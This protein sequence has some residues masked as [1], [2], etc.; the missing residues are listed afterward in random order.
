MNRADTP[1][2]WLATVYADRHRAYGGYA[3]RRAEARHTLRGLA[4]GLVF[5]ALVFLVPM[6]VYRWQQRMAARVPAEQVRVVTYHQLAPPPPI[7]R[8]EPPAPPPEAPVPKAKPRYAPPVVKPD[9]EVPDEELPP[10]VEE[11]ALL[12]PGPQARPGDSVIWA[13]EPVAVAEPEPEPEPEP[14]APV[15]PFVMAEVM[16]EFPGG[17]E[18]LYAHLAREIRYPVPA[19]ENGIQ[20]KVFVRFVVQ[21]DGRVT[22]AQVLRGI[23]GG[24]DEE[25]LRVVRALPRWTPGRQNDRAVPVEYTLPVRFVLK[26]G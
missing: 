6:G 16:P 7:E 13:E 4:A 23:G 20:G 19:M 12:D 9:E 21:A 18:A 24:C 25:A 15:K 1:T 5:V 8:R 2:G 26:D 17:I 22:D 14:P 3:L 11:L 10:T